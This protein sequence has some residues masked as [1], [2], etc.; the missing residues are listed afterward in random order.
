MGCMKC[1]R[2]TVE[3]RLFCDTCLEVMKR[4]PVK[5]GIAI[6]LPKRKDVSISKRPAAPRRRQAPKTEE[7]IRRLRRRIRNLVILWLLTLLLAAAMVYP[8][9]RFIQDLDLHKIGQNYTTFTEETAET[10]PVGP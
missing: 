9:V 3:D 7:I 5:P 10:V 6:Q 1:G 4:Y 2:D 8:T